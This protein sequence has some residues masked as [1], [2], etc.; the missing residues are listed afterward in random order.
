MPSEG[1]R[2]AKLN[3]VILDSQVDSLFKF[4]SGKADI[5]HPALLNQDLKD[6]S[7]PLG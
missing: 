5:S 7:H 1:E 4:E 2:Q 3:I 6:V